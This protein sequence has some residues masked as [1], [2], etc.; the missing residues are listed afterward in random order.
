MRRSSSPFPFPFPL[1]MALDHERFEVYELSRCWSNSLRAMNH[2][3]A[4]S[5][6]KT[7]TGSG[8]GSAPRKPDKNQIVIFFHDE[9]ASSA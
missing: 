3:P 7:G 4:L 6:R 2:H 5:A 8:T 1:P 9:A